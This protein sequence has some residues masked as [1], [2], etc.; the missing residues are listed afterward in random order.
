M[1]WEFKKVSPFQKERKKERMTKPP[2]AMSSFHPHSL[3]DDL[4]REKKPVVKN[5]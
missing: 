1:G 5:F 2:N 3:A 4:K